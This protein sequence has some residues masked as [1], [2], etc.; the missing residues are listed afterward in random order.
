MVKCTSG[1][2]WSPKLDL[3]CLTHIDMVLLRPFDGAFEV[4]RV[5]PPE[6]AGASEHVE[7]AV[8]KNCRTYLELRSQGYETVSDRQFRVMKYTGALCVALSELKTAKPA[9]H[10]YL[11]DFELDANAVSYLSPRLG[12]TLSDFDIERRT[13]AERRGMS[14]KDFEPD[15]VAEVMGP[16][17]IEVTGDGWTVQLTGYAWGDFDAD[18]FQDLLLRG[19]AW[20]T[21]GTWTSVRLFR[22]TRT[23]AVGKLSIAWE[24]D[25]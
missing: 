7:K 14:W 16:D 21:E 18:G 6:V 3:D 19:D 13:E 12:P 15:I 20:L 2:R 1:I 10:N 25:L 9:R 23:S 8:M 17:E 5:S 24:Y 22:L 11:S 4:E